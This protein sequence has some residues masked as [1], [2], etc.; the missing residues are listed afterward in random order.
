MSELLGLP[1]F[2]ATA[3][4]A[5]RNLSHWRHFRRPCGTIW[6]FETWARESKA[7]LVRKKGQSDTDATGSS[8]AMSLALT[9]PPPPPPPHP[10]NDIF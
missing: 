2:P 9:A 7:R 3:V 4:F 5:A 1:T 10:A 8:P 6:R